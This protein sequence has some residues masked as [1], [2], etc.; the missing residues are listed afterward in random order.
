MIRV[1]YTFDTLIN[2]CLI[3]KSIDEVKTINLERK[4]AIEDIQAIG[5]PNGPAFF[6]NDSH[7]TRV[8]TTTETL[9][10]S[11]SETLYMKANCK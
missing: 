2:F 5:P 6:N 9:T 1:F 11:D 3:E 4:Y 7:T 8:K 10:T